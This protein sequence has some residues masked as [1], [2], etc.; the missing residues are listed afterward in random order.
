MTYNITAI[1]NA[2]NYA[3]LIV[4]TNVF[5]GDWMVY[6]W[7]III[8]AVALFTISKSDNSLPTALTGASFITAIS[9]FILRLIVV[10]GQSLLS[11]SVVVVL[12]VLTAL[13]AAYR[14]MQKG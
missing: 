5:S 7:L 9:A 1:T 14:V 3:E 13:F 2:T 10:N 6:G 11:T 8:F 12:G 4:K